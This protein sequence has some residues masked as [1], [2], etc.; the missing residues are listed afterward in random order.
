[1]VA[2]I[3]SVLSMFEVAAMRDVAAHLT[4]RD[5][6]ATAGR[7]AKGV[8]DNEQAAQSPQLQGLLDKAASAL[9]Q[10][11]LF[12]SLA[13]PRHFVRLMLSRYGPGMQYGR[14]VDDAVM[15]DARTDLSFTL[16]LTD[17]AD[18]EGGA[19]VMEDHAEERM[20]RP[21]AG[22]AVLY[23]TSA[24]HRVEPVTHGQ[25]LAIVGWVQSWVREADRREVLHD[26]DVAARGVF[27]GSGKT[28]AFDSLHKAKTNLLRMWADG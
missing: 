7:F 2:V 13:R 21:Q 8:K 20:F 25:R 16:F 15:A 9:G 1:M 4:F 19:L 24:L 23:P 3:G 10:N 22:D 12:Q 17:P 27:E 5:G 11:E 14:H 6:R 26:L 18:Y 28:D